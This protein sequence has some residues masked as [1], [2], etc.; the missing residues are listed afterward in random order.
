MQEFFDDLESE[1]GEQKPLL[2]TEKSV[3]KPQ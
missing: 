1:L 3:A 2:P